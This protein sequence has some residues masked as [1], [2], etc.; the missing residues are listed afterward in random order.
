MFP[1]QI[2][3]FEYLLLVKLADAADLDLDGF[4]RRLS[5]AVLHA[6]DNSQNVGRFHREW[7]DFAVS[8]S[9]RRMMR[10][11]KKPFKIIEV[12]RK[13]EL[14]NFDKAKSAA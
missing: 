1:E 7:H 11:E 10:K 5:D 14:R 9:G 12:P 3:K 6:I 2:L 4:Q 8:A 13:K